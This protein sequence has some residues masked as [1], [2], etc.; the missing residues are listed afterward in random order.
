M[1]VCSDKGVYMSVKV[2]ITGANYNNKGAQSMLF[3]TI[4]EIK[5]RI[6]DSEVYFGCATG[7]PKLS[8]VLF[9][10][11]N[12]S[13]EGRYIALGGGQALFNFAVAIA[14]ALIFMVKGKKSNI[15]NFFDA[16]KYISD[17]DMIIDVSG[18]ALGDKWSKRTNENFLNTIRLAKRHNIPIFIMPQSF[19]PFRYSEK[20]EYLHEEIK[21][22][23]AYP[24]VVYAREQEGY[25]FLTKDYGLTNVKLSRDLVLQNKEVELSHVFENTPKLNVP[26]LETEGNVGVLPNN[27]CFV[28]GDEDMVLGHY[29]AIVDELLRH[30]K[31]V[32]LFRHSAKDLEYCKKIYELYEGV[33]QVHLLQDDFS[34][35]EYEEFVKKFEFIICSRFHGIVHA[36][37]N[38][39]PAIALGWAVKYRELTGAVGQGEYIFD[40]TDKACK[41][42]ALV[43]AVSNM[44][45]NVEKEK[46]TIKQHVV[47][48]QAENCFECLSEWVGKN[49]E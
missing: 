28:H 32:Y 14:K 37:K 48:L 31:S 42:E 5:K 19:G 36:Y 41:Q 49:H 26:N 30:G 25:D 33:E 46:E 6:P 3:I 15:W 16:K 39:V 35:L 40:I 8:Q 27:Q 2:L 23:L 38:Y 34:C 7:D 11:I 22:L 12:F 4:D 20:L 10:Q 45:A 29:K 1:F 24:E 17:M 43:Q 21:N 13:R 47:E 9:K 44:I 18:F